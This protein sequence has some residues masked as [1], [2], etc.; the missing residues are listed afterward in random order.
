MYKKKAKLYIIDYISYVRE[1]FIYVLC[2]C[3]D[4]QRKR[5][6]NLNSHCANFIFK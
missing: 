6:A 2:E 3:I 5:I 1:C 4:F